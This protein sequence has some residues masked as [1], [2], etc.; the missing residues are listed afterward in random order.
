MQ[1]STGSRS[2]VPALSSWSMQLSSAFPRSISA[3]R[4][5]EPFFGGNFNES[6]IR[7]GDMAQGGE[8]TVDPLDKGSQVRVDFISRLLPTLHDDF[9]RVN[10]RRLARVSSNPCRSVSGTKLF[11]KTRDGIARLADDAQLRYL[12]FSACFRPSCSALF[13]ST[14]T[15][16]AMSFACLR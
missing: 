1:P 10:K 11:K 13:T 8:V 12:R 4:N 9:I 16:C 3:A 6:G 14:P 5:K 2:L 7:K 15:F